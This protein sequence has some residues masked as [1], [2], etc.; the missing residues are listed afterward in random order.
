VLISL[1]EDDENPEKA[2]EFWAKQKVP[3][4][5]FHAS[6]EILEKFPLHGIPYF[7]LL[8]ASGKVT[9]SQA[10]LDEDGLR[11]AVAALTG[12]PSSQSPTSH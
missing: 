12:S 11:A 4:P 2:V 10:G 3:W 7:I 8:D 1:D 9:L 6:K 5:N